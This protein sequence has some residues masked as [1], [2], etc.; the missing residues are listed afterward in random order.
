M[1]FSITF[2][3]LFLTLLASIS[4]LVEGETTDNP[5]YQVSSSS[6][7]L[8]SLVQRPIR[9]RV[10]RPENLPCSRRLLTL[11]EDT[12][13]YYNKF[14]TIILP[15]AET[16]ISQKPSAPNRRRSGVDIGSFYMNDERE[17]LEEPPEELLRPVSRRRKNRS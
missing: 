11:C 5:D 16:L 17:G 6:P 14:S 2:P 10:L 9:R 12:P 15:E 4:S 3:V 1:E 8:E 13:S 7:L